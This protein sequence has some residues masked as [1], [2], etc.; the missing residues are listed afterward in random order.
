MAK[1]DLAI[2]HRLNCIAQISTNTT[3]LGFESFMLKLNKQAQQKYFTIDGAIK[4]IQPVGE[5]LALVCTHHYA[6]TIRL[7]DF[8]IIDTIWNSRCVKGC[9]YQNK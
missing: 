9:F 6:V 5:D 2:T 4:S 1:S 3:V 7:T 8:K